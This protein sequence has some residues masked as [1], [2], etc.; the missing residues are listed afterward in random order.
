[1]YRIKVDE[2]GGGERDDP[3]RVLALH[4][5]KDGVEVR[6]FDFDLSPAGARGLMDEV[7]WLEWKEGS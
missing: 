7:R 5:Y 2:R 1:M 3:R 6:A 4:V